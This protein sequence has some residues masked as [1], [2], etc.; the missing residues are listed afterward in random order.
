MEQSEWSFPPHP[1]FVLR[2][3]EGRLWTIGSQAQWGRRGSSGRV[4]MRWINRW[5]GNSPCRRRRHSSSAQS[6][7]V[8]LSTL[9]SPGT[10]EGGWGWLGD[11]S[12]DCGSDGSE[13]WETFYQRVLTH[14]GGRRMME[15]RLLNTSFFPAS[16]NLFSQ[17]RERK[18]HFLLYLH[19]STPSLPSSLLLL[20]TYSQLNS[21]EPRLKNVLDN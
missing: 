21:S 1:I 17:P 19:L 9:R 16:N 12:V 5:P 6:S 18:M 11:R 3:R 2:G 13:R 20:F 7:G 8:W 4:W 10:A 14:D 15:H